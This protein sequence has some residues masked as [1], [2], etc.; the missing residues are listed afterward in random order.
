MRLIAGS[1]CFVMGGM[2]AFLYA[3][4]ANPDREYQPLSLDAG[5]ALAH[6]NAA[7]A[8][9]DPTAA[10]PDVR[11]ALGNPVVA[12]AEPEVAKSPEASD[13]CAMAEDC[14]DQ[15]LWSIYERTPKVDTIKLQER[16]KVTVK[17]KGH[18]RTITKTVTKLAD[19]DFTWKDPEAAQKAGMPVPVYVIGGMDRHF[20]LRLYHLVRALDDAG[21]APGMTSGFRDDYRQSIASGNKAAIDSSYHGGSRRGGFGHGLAA[22][23]VSVKGD[24]PS[25]R[26]SSTE[27]L[28]KWIDAHGKEYGIGRPYLDK[29]PPHVGPIDGKEYVGHRGGNMKRAG[30]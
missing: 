21:L 26:W 4:A 20:K 9:P 23:L 15:Y 14:I 25:E 30:L 24:T 2:A 11:S 17:K 6:S 12:P 22:D 7:R 28:W 19:E 13:G 3:S 5:T 29:D 18:T 10:L 16:M 27:S 1:H 8:G